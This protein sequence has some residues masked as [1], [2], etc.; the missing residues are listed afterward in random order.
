MWLLAAN[1]LS[2]FSLV[3]RTGVSLLFSNMSWVIT[4]SLPTLYE[5]FSKSFWSMSSGRRIF[6]GLPRASQ[7]L[8]LSF[9]VGSWSGLASYESFLAKVDQYRLKEGGYIIHSY[10]T[11]LTFCSNAALRP[12]AILCCT[13]QFSSIFLPMLLSLSLHHLRIF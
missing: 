2:M 8:S 7:L 5:L 6:H 1:S 3:V 4:A 9:L 12:F 13:I 10:V 11:A